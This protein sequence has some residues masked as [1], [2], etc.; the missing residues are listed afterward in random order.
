MGLKEFR[1]WAMGRINSTCR[2][3]PR[4]QE[5]K[6]FHPVANERVLDFVFIH[7]PRVRRHDL[8][9]LR[10]GFEQARDEPREGDGGGGVGAHRGGRQG[11]GGGGQR[12]HQLL[13]S[14]PL[15]HRVVVHEFLQHVQEL[16]VAHLGV[17]RPLGVP[18]QVACNS[19]SSVVSV[20]NS[21][22]FLY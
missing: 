6:D 2:A 21:R 14:L 3:P 20:L 10:R 19:Q 13:Q 17:E 7:E 5:A 16:V 12:L 4:E 18:L 11:S 9:E 8:G 22:K 15:L 1:L